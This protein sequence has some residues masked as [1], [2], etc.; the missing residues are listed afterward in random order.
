MSAPPAWLLRPVIRDEKSWDIM[1]YSGRQWIDPPR[2]P[3]QASAQRSLRILLTTFKLKDF[4]P[5]ARLSAR[6][7]ASRAGHAA[8][9]PV[10][11]CWQQ[12]DWNQSRPSCPR[13]TAHRE[14]AEAGAVSDLALNGGIICV[15]RGTIGLI[16]K[17]TIDCRMNRARFEFAA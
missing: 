6:S 14:I 15:L 10:R 3:C 13:S 12:L 17:Y 16:D 7:R 5:A 8:R 11:T 4:L 9:H 2:T 1:G